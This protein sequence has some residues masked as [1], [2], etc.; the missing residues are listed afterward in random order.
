MKETRVSELHVCNLFSSS[1]QD[2]HQDW[3]SHQEHIVEKSEW[4]EIGKGPF[5]YIF[6]VTLHTLLRC[7]IFLLVC[8]K[9]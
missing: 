8:N 4:R 2:G 7:K 6:S 5:F 3:P 9:I 1:N